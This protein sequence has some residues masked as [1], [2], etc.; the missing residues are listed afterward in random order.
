MEEDRTVQWENSES[1]TRHALHLSE[2]LCLTIPHH[3]ILLSMV[4]RLTLYWK[5]PELLEHGDIFLQDRS[6][7]SSSSSPWCRPG[8]WKILADHTLRIP[9]WICICHHHYKIWVQSH[10]CDSSSTS[11]KREVS[12]LVVI[13]LR[14]ESEMG[15]ACS[16]YGKDEKCI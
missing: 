14:R 11:M 2:G 5:Q 1:D 16:T 8:G 4:C 12:T 13:M 7:S 6:S 9:V 3:F 10:Q 15:R